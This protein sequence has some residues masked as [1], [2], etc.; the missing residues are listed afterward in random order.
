MSDFCERPVKA[1]PIPRAL[2]VGGL[3][4]GDVAAGIE[5]L[6]KLDESEI[7]KTPC[8]R[9]VNVQ[10]GENSIFRFGNQNC[11]NEI[12]KSENQFFGSII[13]LGVKISEESFKDQQ[14]QKTTLKSGKTLGR[15]KGDLIHRRHTELRVHLYVPKEDACPSPLKETAHTDLDVL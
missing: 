1:P 5:E 13:L 11:V 8:Q 10:K 15:F 9:S 14:K 4:K 6:D 3:W 2:V 7:S 12:M